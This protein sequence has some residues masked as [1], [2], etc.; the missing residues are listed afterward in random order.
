MDK[1]LGIYV[2]GHRGLVGSAIV[3]RLRDDGYLNI[4][5]RSHEELD[6]TNQE[7]TRRFFREAQPSYVFHAAGRVGGIG[8]NSAL[9]AT[10]IAENILMSANVIMAAYEIGVKKLLFF[11]SSCIYPKLCPQPIKEEYL[12]TG[13]LEETNAPYAIAKISGIE[14]CKAYNRQYGTD[15]RAIMPTNLYGRGDR[16]AGSASHVI[17]AI[18]Q[19]MHEAKVKGAA[20]VKLWGTGRPLR[21][22]LHSDD[23]AR[24]AT[25]IMEC[26]RKTFCAVSGQEGVLNVGSGAEIAIRDVAEEIRAAV[27]FDGEIVWDIDMPDGTPRKLVDIARVSALGWRPLIMLPDGLRDAY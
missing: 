25:L 24:A 1:D 18:I 8:A 3:K 27:G 6:L 11:G 22:F 14:L 16:Y 9:P 17:P 15:Y 2:A 19:K 26:S 13:P 12:L 5:T 4:I 10:F 20:S 23:L 7:A 21:D